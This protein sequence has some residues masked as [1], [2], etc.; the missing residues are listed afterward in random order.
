[1]A[2]AEGYFMAK[3]ELLRFELIEAFRQGRINRS[4][5]AETLELSERQ[6]SRLAKRVREDGLPSILH[7]NRGRAPRN[8]LPE[9]VASLYLSLYEGK[10]RNFNFKHALEWIHLHEGIPAEQR[11]CYESFRKLCR[12]KGLGKVKR[13]RVSKAR[14]IRERVSQEGAVLQM[15]GSHHVWYGKDEDCL[16]ALIDDATSKIP[17]ATFNE[18]ESTW[19][20]IKALRR[21]VEK[22]GI[23][24]TILTD[25]AGW[26]GGTLK[27]PNFSQFG[28]ICDELGIVLIRTST[29]QAKGR[30][31]RLFRTTQDRL[32]AEL[33]M[34]D[35]KTRAHAN[36][37]LEQCFIPA[38]N[39][40]FTIAARSDVKRY[41]TPSPHLD[42][43]HIFCLKH[44]RTI[45]KNQVISYC[46]KTYR[47]LN[48]EWGSLWKREVSI[49]EQQDGRLSFHLGTQKLDHEEF[50]QPRMG[51]F[52]SWA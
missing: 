17:E 6:V 12:K 7:K 32:I 50:V 35:V 30:V 41:R 15:D 26:A 2:Q 47:I 42:L 19:A 51:P 46:G 36:Q 25:Q 18:S 14:I 22:E 27:R 49:H 1:M 52:K 10:Y 23:P 21:V 11:I 31:E 16:V 34:H 29:A 33:E 28:R 5:T 20:C 4:E 38:W 24:G 9:Q 40:Q 44:S 8:K 48:R 13:R 39:Q 3:R 37:Y 45:G 43:N